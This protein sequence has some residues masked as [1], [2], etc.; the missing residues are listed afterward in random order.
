MLV[1]IERKY[2]IMTVMPTTQ[3]I[4]IM[5]YINAAQLYKE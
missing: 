4:K 3:G 5:F 1:P 2:V